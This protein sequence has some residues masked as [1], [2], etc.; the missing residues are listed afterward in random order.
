MSIGSSD[1]GVGEMV[2][3]A[4]FVDFDVEKFRAAL[5]L[6]EFN[7]TINLMENMCSLLR[8]IT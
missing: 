2:E 7:I 1:L 6:N 5:P 8:T 3:E 4:L